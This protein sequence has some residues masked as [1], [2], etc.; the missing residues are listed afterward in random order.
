MTTWLHLLRG[1][2]LA[3]ML[4]LVIL[5]T[6]SACAQEAGRPET[7]GPQVA[8]GDFTIS[9]PYIHKNLTV[10]LV[11]GK[12]RVEGKEFLTLQE[13]L[14]KKVVVVNET[15]NVNEL[16]IENRSS[17]K[18]IFIQ[19]GSIVRGGQQDRVLSHDLILPPK[20]GKVAIEAFCVE[21]GRWSKRGGE[22]VSRFES[23]SNLL[24]G[25]DLK[26]AAKKSKVQ[27]E[28]WDNVSKS[29]T[30]LREKLGVEVRS[31]ASPT[32]LELAYSNDAVKRSSDEYIKAL[33]GI[34]EG[35]SDVIGYAFAI[36][37]TV[38]SADVYA[39]SGLFRKLWPK[40]LASSATEAIT[41]HEE[42][43]TPAI[44]SAD[45]VRECFSDAEGGKGEQKDLN[46]R[47][48]VVTQETDKNI[49][50]ETRDRKESDVWI[51]RNYMK[52]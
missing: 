41:E 25:K 45:A 33:S 2:F 11:H 24:A 39:S 13:G 10:F 20:S 23:S 35:K 21:Q 7:P 14:A 3:K 4:A 37:G 28:V 47:V 38:N 5:A 15:G 49:L 6:S 22:S 40:L 18:D 1:E 26:L 32:S 19:A 8:A 46:S 27:A 12:N 50:F 31:D 17:T 44:P 34:I 29:Q 48:R 51:H 36:N 9:G 16:S 43:S 52:K 42:G 30:K